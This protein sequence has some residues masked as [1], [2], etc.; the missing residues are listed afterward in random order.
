MRPCW[1]PC[2]LLLAVATARAEDPK[3]LHKL[4]PAELAACLEADHQAVLVGRNGLREVAGYMDRRPE[5]FPEEKLGEPRLLRR[6][7]KEAVWA[8]WQ[9]GLDYM[10]ALDAIRVRHAAYFRVSGDA[11]EQSF[12]LGY[13]AMLAQYRAAMEFVT[14]ADR[15]PELDKVLNEPVPELGLPANTYARMKLRFLNPIIA[16]RFA[17]REAL[18]QTYNGGQLPDIRAVITDDAG[19]LWK[20]G[21][22]RG[23]IMTVKNATKIVRSAADAAWLPV[24]TGVSEWMGDTKVYRVGRSLISPAQ[25]EG[26]Q[27]LLIPGDVLVERRE[28]YLSNVGLPGFWSHAALYLGTATDRRATFGN[29]PDVQAWVRAQG[30]PS[31]D[32]ETLLAGRHPEINGEGFPASDK[33][34]V[35]VIEAISEGVTLTTLEH[36]ADCDS[37]GVLRPRRSLLER[38]QALVR[39][40]HY[41]GRP[42]D[43]EFDFATDAEL[44][45]TEL[46][47]KA[48][49]PRQGYAGLKFELTEMLGRLL[50][51]ANEIVRQHAASEGTPGQQF[52]LVCFLDGQERAKQAVEA[53]AAIF[54]ASWQRP[55]WHVL[56]QP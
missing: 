2:L 12:L 10:V 47:Y 56:K 19:F 30:E 8:A 34:P 41:E 5:I 49:E 16:T 52:D 31:G 39:A 42:Y 48:Y 24:Q 20:Q 37:I 40:L 1:I 46:V 38:A 6:E 54:N 22:G 50:L 3:P 45:C 7:E 55:K 18:R 29:D 4:S 53:S 14:R 36:T 43:F 25:V 21:L 27:K 13:A 11:G 26:L 17:A 44:V 28:W 9:R 51:P 35:R 15:N 32:F 33:K 23:E